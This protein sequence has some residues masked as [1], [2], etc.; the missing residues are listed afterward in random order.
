MHG[1]KAFKLTLRLEKGSE[2]VFMRFKVQHN[3]VS[4]GTW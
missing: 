3:T 4:T 1:E 2:R